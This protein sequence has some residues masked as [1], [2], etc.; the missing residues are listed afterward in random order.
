MG[1]YSENLF[2]YSHPIACNN[3]GGSDRR[4]GAP[5]FPLLCEFRS[6]PGSLYCANH[7]AFHWYVSFIEKSRFFLFLLCLVIMV[8]GFIAWKL[9][10]FS[11]VSVVLLSPEASSELYST[12][13]FYHFSR[14]CCWIDLCIYQR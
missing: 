2:H 11:V 7:H 6:R 5:D 4:Y 14:V 3:R 8:T 9:F 1:I 12:W 13:D 10:C